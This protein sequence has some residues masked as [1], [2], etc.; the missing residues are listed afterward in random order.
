MIWRRPMTQVAADLGISDVALHRICRRHRIPA[1]GRG[2][3][4]KVAA[5]KTPRQP[6]FR[7]VADPRLDRIL[8]RK[9]AVRQPPAAV[10]EA[11]TKARTALRKQEADCR[12]PV[13]SVEGSHPLALRLR[14]VL[15]RAKPDS[16]GLIRLTDPKLPSLTI[17]LAAAD[18]AMAVFSRLVL[19]AE[20]LGYAPAPGDNGLMLMCDGEAVTLHIS[21]QTDRVR[22]EV[23]EKEASALRKW[24]ADQERRRRRGEWAGNWGRPEIPKWERVPNGRLT[25]EVD[26]GNHWDGLRRMFADGRR[27]RAEGVIDQALGAVAAVAMARKVRRA[28]EERRR[29]EQEEMERR[30]R[31][32]ERRRVLEEKR[33]ELLA[34]QMQLFTDARRVEEFVDDYLARHCRSSL[35]ESCRRFLDWAQEHARTLRNA[36]SPE[37][38]AAVLDRYRLMDDGT[39][40]GS[41]TKFDRHFAGLPDTSGKGPAG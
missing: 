21:E 8:I 17:S 4:A 32:A 34:L 10:R 18:R 20:A 19:G 5:G 7:E 31:E 25:I 40:I 33:A 12:T 26:R 3:W 37:R 35:P 22:H 9:D 38:L 28:E 15:K 16:D 29:R 2:Y 6:L 27:Q 36:G 30:R 1:P 24:E 14:E 39:E 13:H 23:T 11:C 41:W